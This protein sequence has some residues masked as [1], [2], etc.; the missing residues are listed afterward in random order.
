MYNKFKYRLITIFLTTMTFQISKENS[1]T[2]YGTL[3]RHWTVVASIAIS[4]LCIILSD[5]EDVTAQL[6][7]TTDEEFLNNFIGL[8]NKSGA[9]TNSYQQEIGKW[10][11]NQ[12][13]NT[14]I[15]M[16]TNDTVAQINNLIDET[17]NLQTP[18]KFKDGISLYTKSLEAERDSYRQ[19]G[20]F[21]KTGNPQLNETSTDLLTD[22]LKYEIEAFKV[23]QPSQ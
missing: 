23:I 9:L 22:S 15:M 16:I 5:G 21:I 6:G 10:E 7:V 20:E 13:N 17:N 14:T 11:N 18:E 1:S 12:Y 4:L 19:F 3:I 8:T 2:A